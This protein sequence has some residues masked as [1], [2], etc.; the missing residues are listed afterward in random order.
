MKDQHGK[1]ITEQEFIKDI[2][3]KTE[4]SLELVKN[5]SNGLELRRELFDEYAMCYREVNNCE[6]D[7]LENG[8]PECKEDKERMQEIIQEVTKQIQSDLL[9]E[10]IHNIQSQFRF[11]RDIPSTEFNQGLEISIKN[12]KKLAEE[13]GIEL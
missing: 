6:V 1:I 4:N 13:K 10:V 9:K 8:C 2:G 7:G 11:T 3:H 12:I 5:K